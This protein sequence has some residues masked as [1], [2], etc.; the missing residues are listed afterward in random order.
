MATQASM[1]FRRCASK[2]IQ[3]SSAPGF[4]IPSTNFHSSQSR[5]IAKN[6]RGMYTCTMI[7]GDGV[8]INIYYYHLREN[9]TDE[10][11]NLD[12]L[13]VLYSIIKSYVIL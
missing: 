4:T 9:F 6:E 10:F 7:P 5:P 11:S 2:L 1:L 3:T 13:I 8:R 12:G